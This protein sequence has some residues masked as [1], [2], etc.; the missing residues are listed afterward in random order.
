MTSTLF[1]E[2][3]PTERGAKVTYLL[4]T[5]SSLTVAQTSNLL[6]L[7]ARAAAKTLERVSRVVPIYEDEGGVWR[8]VEE[9]TFPEISPY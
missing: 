8:V 7:S 9:D 5:R 4:L 3:T 1:R 6:G 2:S